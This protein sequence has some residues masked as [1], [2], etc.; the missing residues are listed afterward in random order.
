MLLCNLFLFS[1]AYCLYSFL[2]HSSAFMEVTTPELYHWRSR[3][4]QIQ[5]AHRRLSET[6]EGIKRSETVF[7]R[8]PT[9]FNPH[10]NKMCISNLSITRFTWERGETRESRYKKL[11]ESMRESPK[12]SGGQQGKADMQPLRK[13]RMNAFHKG[14]GSPGSLSPVGQVFIST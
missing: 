1:E 6:E 3:A 2:K 13:N 11:K 14:P 5:V 12:S 9:S 10:I 4:L 7:L 8:F